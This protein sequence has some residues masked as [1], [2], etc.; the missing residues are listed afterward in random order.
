MEPCA[1]SRSRC[2]RSASWRIC[3]GAASL[4]SHQHICAQRPDPPALREDQGASLTKKAP[5]S[6]ALFGM[7]ANGAP[8]RAAKEKQNQ[9]LTGSGTQ[10]FYQGFLGFH[11]RSVPPDKP[12]PQKK[13]A[14][15]AGP[16]NGGSIR[17]QLGGASRSEFR[18]N[19]PQLASVM[20]IG[21][22]NDDGHFYGWGRA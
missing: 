2:V 18:V 9:R 4:G 22:F 14:A 7:E 17:K 20:L 10:L 5:A 15:P 11:A 1:R 8:G 12:L 16:R 3:M 19:G 21:L 6:G 13:T